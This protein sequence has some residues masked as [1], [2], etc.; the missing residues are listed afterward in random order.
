LIIAALIVW[1]NIGRVTVFAIGKALDR[2]NTEIT[3]LISDFFVTSGESMGFRAIQMT[4]QDGIPALRFEFT[5]DSSDLA[6][7]NINSFHNMSSI[8][9]A[10]EL[11][12]TPDEIPT[13]IK[14]LVQSTRLA[15]DIYIYDEND[16][17]AFN[18][19]IKPEEIADFLNTN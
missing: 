14:S 5:F 9:I 18:R 11:G 6:S 17:V 7:V 12:I 2:Y 15:V 4:E 3:E 16:N 8:E 1:L 10:S 13:E 19:L